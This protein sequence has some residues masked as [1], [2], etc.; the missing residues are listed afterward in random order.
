MAFSAARVQ[1]AADEEVKILRKELANFEKQ[2]D[3]DSFIQG[4]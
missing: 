3:V 1:K 4:E 2:D